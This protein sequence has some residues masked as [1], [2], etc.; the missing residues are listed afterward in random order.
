MLFFSVILISISISTVEA[1][2]RALPQKGHNN[3]TNNNTDYYYRPHR[4]ARQ[5]YCWSGFDT[6]DRGYEISVDYTKTITNDLFSLLNKDVSNVTK[7]INLLTS[8]N[9]KIP[10]NKA[11]KVENVTC[12]IGC[13]HDDVPTDYAIWMM[14]QYGYRPANAKELISFV[15][16][17]PKLVSQ[18]PLVA[19]G[20][21]GKD[22]GK[23]IYVYFTKSSDQKSIV[24]GIRYEESGSWKKE[25]R[26]FLAI[27]VSN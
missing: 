24:P 18:F 25:Q 11:G 10:F 23:I 7:N 19:L 27:K 8:K 16:K 1:K 26:R 15:K 6:N 4:S 3:N 20:S 12:F 5:G 13:F 2:F 17:Y 22:A 21:T 14:G 9:F